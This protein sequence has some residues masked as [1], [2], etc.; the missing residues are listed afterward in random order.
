MHARADLDPELFLLHSAWIR[1]LARRLAGAAEAE[2]LVQETWLAALERPRAARSLRAWLAGVLSNRARQARRGEARR[3]AREQR[4]ARGADS[5]P[6]ASETYEAASTGRALADLVLALEEPFRAA[7]LLRYYEGLPPRRI[8]ERLQVPVRTVNSRL[9]RGLERLRERWQQRER[10]LGGHGEAW[11]RSLLLL[12]GPTSTLGAP[13]ASSGAV[14]PIG[15]V[16]M[17]AKIW[18]G[19]AVLGAG[20]VALWT[21]SPRG[22]VIHEGEL[23]LVVVPESAG[24]LAQV[25]RTELAYPPAPP[26]SPVELDDPGA[27]T[28]GPSEPARAAAVPPTRR[29]RGR[30]LDPE[31]RPLRGIEVG[32][33]AW[34]GDPEADDLS[35]TSGPDGSFELEV[36]QGGGD[37]RALDPALVTVLSG[38]VRAPSAVEPLVVVAPRIELAGRVVDQDGAPLGEVTVRYEHPRGFG[39]RFEAILDAT[40]GGDWRTRSDER[41]RF[42]LAPLPAIAGSLLVAELAGFEPWRG[43]VPW[44]SDR[45]LVLALVRGTAAAPVV[46]G[47]VVDP[48]HRPVPGAWVSLG[49]GAAVTDWAGEFRL[50]RANALDAFELRALKSGFRMATLRAGEDAR[51][52][53]LWPSYAVLVL[54]PPP[55]SLSGR[56]VD[57]RGE[58]RLGMVVWIADPTPFGILQDDM[59]ASAEY[60]LGDPE[61][62]D[63]YWHSHTTDANG[64]FRI[65]GLLEREYTLSVMN[66]RTLETRSA[67]PFRPDAAAVELA[68]ADGELRRVA[69]RVVARDG[70]GL[71]GVTLTLRGNAFGGIWLDAQSSQSDG[72][73]RFAFDGVGGRA[74][75]LSASGD[76][77]VPEWLLVEAEPGAETEVELVVAVRCTL[78]V[79]LGAAPA[80]ADAL[81][82]LDQDG[83]ELLLSRIGPSGSLRASEFPLVDGR[84][85]PL[86]V[87]DSARTLVLHKDGAEALRV[88]LALRP[89][90]LNLIRP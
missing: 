71:P 56:V 44:H 57:A 34:G 85:E 73:G 20:A 49:S 50:E 21:S 52:A 63:A 24:P 3:R 7:V 65:D 69:G 13:A 43:E 42:E 33:E 12:A 54:G 4:A 45:D 41:G 89:G 32:Y 40:E 31:A 14:L 29:V 61:R 25:E 70:R 15:V 35:A 19:A 83:G 1:G 64:R 16:L 37:L 26:R 27:R 81:R 22:R 82:V 74:L 18:L 46:V 77:V 84:S 86:G 2:D 17:N 47:R 38:R 87:G 59:E 80:R 6:P 58:P 72:E 66:R 39:A 11:V 8:A 28:P 10:A 67:G 48:E 55:L 62:G 68:F 79:D 53:P 75:M 88:P 76:D 78:Q 90:T 51:G 60:F 23:P 30:V 9:T 5:E 36:P